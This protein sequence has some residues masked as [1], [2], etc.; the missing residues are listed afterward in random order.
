[1][2]PVC[3]RTCLSGSTQ[4][5]VAFS[6]SAHSKEPSL[7]DIGAI[8]VFPG[9]ENNKGSKAFQSRVVSSVG[10]LCTERENDESHTASAWKPGR[11]SALL[12]G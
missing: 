2:Q 8:R 5:P 7:W 11:A 10:E 4:E 3:K 6:R 12:A 9:K 1:M